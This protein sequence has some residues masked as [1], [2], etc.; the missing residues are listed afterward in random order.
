MYKN[1][2]IAVKMGFLKAGN[3][4]PKDEHNSNDLILVTKDD[5]MS[6]INKQDI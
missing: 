3:G 4:Y 5:K 2:L 6:S 1:Y